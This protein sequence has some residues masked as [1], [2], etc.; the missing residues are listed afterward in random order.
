MAVA[1]AMMGG[2]QETEIVGLG[3]AEGQD[4][5][6]AFHWLYGEPSIRATWA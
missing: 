1:V 2:A 6:S 3:A 4:E 5:A